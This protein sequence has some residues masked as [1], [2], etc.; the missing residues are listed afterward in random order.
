[1]LN[2]DFPIRVIPLRLLSRSC[3]MI[4]EPSCPFFRLIEVVDKKRHKSASER[5]HSER[6]LSFGSLSDID[7]ESERKSDFQFDAKDIW[8]AGETDRAY[9]GHSSIDVADGISAQ[10]CRIEHF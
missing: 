8:A 1:M 3:G 2:D 9:V 6:S 5:P 10:V 7:R 4:K